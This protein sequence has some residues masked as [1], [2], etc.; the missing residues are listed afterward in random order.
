MNRL[1]SISFSGQS[2]CYYFSLWPS[3]FIFV[4]LY[5]HISLH[6]L[7]MY[8]MEE[9]FLA[10]MFLCNTEETG[11]FSIWIIV[12]LIFLI[13]YS[14]NYTAKGMIF[15]YFI[16]IFAV[17]AVRYATFYYYSIKVSLFFDMTR[18]WTFLLMLAGIFHRKCVYWLVGEWDWFLLN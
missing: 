8:L 2:S 18:C 17:S 6:F 1:G 3:E 7:S 10:A 4:I 15:S 13:P 12:V 5:Q 14:T 9:P 16:C 11:Y